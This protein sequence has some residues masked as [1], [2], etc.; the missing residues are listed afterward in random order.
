MMENEGKYHRMDANMYSIDCKTGDESGGCSGLE[1][2]RSHKAE[3]LIGSKNAR[4]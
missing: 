4:V 2:G 3:G 1:R